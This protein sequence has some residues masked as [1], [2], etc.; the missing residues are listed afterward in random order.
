MNKIYLIRFEDGTRMVTSE[1][2][3]KLV[4]SKLSSG[5][6][7]IKELDEDDYYDNYFYYS[8]CKDLESFNKHELSYNPFTD[9]K[10]G[11]TV[12]DNTRRTKDD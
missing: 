11:G 8:V 7:I 10:L 3:S 5:P 12:I 6:Y 4:Q 9:D 1:I 2:D